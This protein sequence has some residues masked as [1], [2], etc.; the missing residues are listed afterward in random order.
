MLFNSFQFIVFFAIVYGLYLILTHRYQNYWLL[1]ASYFFYGSWDWRFLGLML[2]STVMDYGFGLLIYH[3]ENEA[4]RKLVLL[5]SITVNLAILFT[6]KYFNFFA[7]SFNRLLSLFHLDLHPVLIQVI[8]PLG[9]SFYTFHNLSY[10]ID[11]YRGRVTPTRSFVSFALYVALFPQLIAG[12]IARPTHLLP[13]IENARRITYLMIREGGWLILL[14]FFK[15]VVLADNMIPFIKPVFENPHTAH[16][17][18]ILF[19]LYAFAFQLYGDFSGYSDI[20]RGLSKLMGFE[21]MLNFHHPYFATNPTEFWKRWHISLSTWLRDYL[22]IPLGGSRHGEWQTYR[23]LL[24]TMLL[25]GLWHGAAWNFVVW[26]LFHGAILAIHRMLKPLSDA[27][28]INRLPEGHSSRWLWRALTLIGFFHITCFS[29]LIFVVKD[30]SHVTL[31]LHNMFHPFV[32]NGWT[33]LITILLFA[34]PLLLMEWAE[35]RTD[36]MPIVKFWPRPVRFVCYAT[37]LAMIILC[38]VVERH[39]FIYFQF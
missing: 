10:I 36:Q 7:L 25:G 28:P 6:F 8:L 12:P 14:G 13:Q 20:A 19:S 18:Q 4:R 26:G 32:L 34:G 27:M 15:K 1:L 24:I 31:L 35:E 23:N 3:A 29:L 33:A 11:V 16:G 39:E 37:V 5:T 9:I 30:L 22:Y 17:T 2:F 38:G 21:L